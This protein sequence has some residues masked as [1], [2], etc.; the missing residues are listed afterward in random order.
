MRIKITFK[1]CGKKQVLPFNYQYP[2]SAWIYKV[3]GRA[4]KEFTRML[5]DLGYK[6]L[7]LNNLVEKYAITGKKSVYVADLGFAKVV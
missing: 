5:H 3:L 1:L 7:F 2:V 6:N 4:D